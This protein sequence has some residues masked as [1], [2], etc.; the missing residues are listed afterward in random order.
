MF[1][2]VFFN[3]LRGLRQVQPVHRDLM[4]AYAATPRQITRTVTLPGALP[5]FFTGLRIASSLAVISALVAEYFGGPVGGPRQGDHLGGLEQQLPAGLGV[6]A[7]RDP[8]RARVLRRDL[9]ARALALAR[10]RT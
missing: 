8:A 6:R 4:R 7:R 5:Y 1:I 3:T 10:T 9:R 2:P